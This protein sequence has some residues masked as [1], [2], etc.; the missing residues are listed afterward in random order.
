MVLMDDP[1]IA[2]DAYA[3][4]DVHTLWGTVDMMVLFVPELVRDSRTA[5]RIVQQI[6]WSSGGDGIVVRSHRQSSPTSAARPSPSPITPPASITS[7]ASSC[8]PA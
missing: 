4:G 7:P 6:D 5:P 3:A 8:P 1:V 2:R